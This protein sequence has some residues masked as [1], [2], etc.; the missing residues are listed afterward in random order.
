MRFIITLVG[1]IVVLSAGSAGADGT[2]SIDNFP[3]AEVAA[4]P[5]DPAEMTREQLF[6]AAHA[7]DSGD[8]GAEDDSLA[9]SYYNESVER[10]DRF[11]MIRL[12]YFYLNGTG[13]RKDIEK[14]QYWFRSYALAYPTANVSEWDGI[15]ESLF[16]GDPLP[17]AFLLE[18]AKRA[19]EYNGS[20]DILMGNYHRLADGD[21]VRANPE[22]AKIW[23]MQAVEKKHPDAL[24]ELAQRL[25]A[26]RSSKDG[27]RV[28]LRLAAEANHPKAQK[29]LGENYLTTG[30][31]LS[32]KY[33]ALVWLVRAQINGVNVE[34]LI[35]KAE[36]QLDE[37]HRAWAREKAADFN[38][39][40]RSQD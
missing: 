16:H 35:R 31:E 33:H 29:E 28:Y 23:L 10:G 17:D 30:Q 32:E 37:Q 2:L 40:P 1:L 21:G 5:D 7:Y 18:M 19:Q 36:Q 25:R 34:T 26:E 11:P 24:Y 3:C 14:A 6:Y 4:F 20:P 8:C 12:G 27:Y 39:A 38:F 9:F 15:V 13:I 22:R